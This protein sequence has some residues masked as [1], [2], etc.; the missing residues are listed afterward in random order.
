[1]TEPK[2]KRGQQSSASSLSNSVARAKAR[3][4]A[5]VKKHPDLRSSSKCAAHSIADHLNCVTMDCWP[6][7][8]TLANSI[9]VRATKTIQRATKQLAKANFIVV[10]KTDGR[11]GPNRYAP[12]FIASDWDIPVPV[13]GQT[14]SPNADSDVRQSYLDIH[15]TSFSTEEAR[16]RGT[17]YWKI[18]FEP[19]ARGALEVR[20]VELLGPNG[21]EILNALNSL[22]AS[23][24]DRLCQCLS[25]GTLSERELSAAKLAVRQA[26]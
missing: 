5:R 10:T 2:T 1:M 6:S 24:V 16:Q 13:A 21:V 25:N 11:Q 26:T 19:R 22:D 15:S 12:V 14:R 17:Q 7:N 18:D 8:K 4:F 20:L 9:G 23:A 3:W